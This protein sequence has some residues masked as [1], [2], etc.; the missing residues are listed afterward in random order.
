MNP[1]PSQQRAEIACETAV[2]ER[3]LRCR[4]QGAFVESEHPFRGLVRALKEI[5]LELSLGQAIES[6]KRSIL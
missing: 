3:V 6:G 4:A 1:P 5:R 2:L